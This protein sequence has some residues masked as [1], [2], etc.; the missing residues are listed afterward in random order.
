MRWVLT[1]LT[2]VAALA[3]TDARTTGVFPGAEWE[4]ASSPEAAGFSSTRLAG[5]REAV[6]QL[7]T[8]GMVVVSGG[9]IVL[10]CGDVAEVSHIASVRKSVLAMLF[11]KYVENGTIKLAK[12]LADLKVTDHGGLSPQELEATVADL[13]AARSGVYHPASNGGDDLADAPPRGSKRHGTYFLYNNWDFNALGTIF[14]QETGRNIYDALET[15]LARPIGMQDFRRE[16]QEKSGD[17][18]QSIH[19][20]YHMHFST[21]DMARIGYL[22]L[23]GGRWVRQQVVPGDWVKRAVTVSTPNTEMNPVQYRD[24]PFGYGLLWWVFD[25]RFDAEGYAGGYTAIGVG[26]QFITVLPRL[27]LVVAHKVKMTPAAQPVSTGQYFTI[28]DALVAAR[29]APSPAVEESRTGV[30]GLSKA[31]VARIDAA[32]NA[33]MADCR[34]LNVGVVRHGKVVFTKAYGEGRLKGEYEY[35]SVSKPVTSTILMGLRREGLIRSLDDNVWTYLPAYDG[36]MPAEYKQARLTLKHLLTHRSGIPHN[37]EPPLTGGRF[38]LK[39]EPGT[40]MLYST[41]AYG[42][43]GQVIEAVTGTSY[44]DAVKRYIGGPV[45]GRSFRAGSTFIAPGAYVYS[46]IEDMARFAAGTMSNRYMPE[47]VLYGEVLRPET[48]NYGY[49]WGVTNLG[50]PDLTAAHGGSNGL[51][52]AHIL[53][54]PRQNDGVVVLAQMRVFAPLDLDALARLGLAALDPA[55]H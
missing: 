33:R 14:E 30:N 43:L 6:K 2:V 38:N 4:R 49:G 54:K 24:G 23:R 52:R 31:T 37:D 18:T 53:L 1:L 16:R 39:F 28:V 7:G 48:G 55:A 34:F 17:L 47:E 9:R 11:G 35:G 41:P 13:L 46:D 29:T 5:V 12:T 44:S 36:A 50:R 22:M 26:G 3:A 40:R 25:G 21:R 32:V 8:T 10:E 51:P 20:A 27:D 45:A 19:P 15:D 42:I